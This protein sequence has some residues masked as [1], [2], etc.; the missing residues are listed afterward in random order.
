MSERGVVERLGDQQSTPVCRP[1]DWVDRHGDVLFRYALRRVGDREVAEELVQECFLAALSARS[2]FDGGSSEQS[3]L[4][5]I[6]K[7]KI[8]DH[9]RRQ[10]R[11]QESE[12]SAGPDRIEQLVFTGKGFWK[13]R[14][15]RWAGDPRA[16]AES[17]EFWEVLRRCLDQLPQR[18]AAAFTLREIEQCT[19]EEVCQ[20]LGLT[21][22]NLWARLHRARLGLRLCLDRHWFDRRETDDQTQPDQGG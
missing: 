12:D 1:G 13:V 20:V 4:V 5:G 9:F 2:R 7:H 14:F 21:E 3:W 22:T 10:S 18:L 11:N 19:S 15:S 16:L 6:L 8:I 17:A